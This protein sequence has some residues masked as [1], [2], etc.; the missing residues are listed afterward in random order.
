MRASVE[1]S[2][3]HE[4]GVGVQEREG[5]GS[6]LHKI[7][8]SEVLSFA[9]IRGLPKLCRRFSLNNEFFMVGG[10]PAAIK[11]FHK[12]YMCGRSCRLLTVRSRSR[13]KEFIDLGFSGKKGK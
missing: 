4:Q 13:G 7:D 12:L 9:Q 6:W 3:K 10:Y 2:I 11:F 8:G 1:G 5:K